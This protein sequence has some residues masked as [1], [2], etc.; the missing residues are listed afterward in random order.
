MEIP[1]RYYE[2]AMHPHSNARSGGRA[3]QLLVHDDEWAEMQRL[4]QEHAAIE[5]IR[6]E[7][8]LVGCMHNVAVL[9]PSRD[10]ASALSRA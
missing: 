3:A 1:M 9:C 4:C 5:V 8:T 7:P 2:F 10:A 6:V